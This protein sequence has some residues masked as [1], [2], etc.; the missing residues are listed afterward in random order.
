M[1]SIHRQINRH[2]TTAS[3]NNSDKYTDSINPSYCNRIGDSGTTSTVTAEVSTLFNSQNT[4]FTGVSF[5]FSGS[6]GKRVL[7]PRYVTKWVN[8][9][10]VRVSSK[11]FT[12]DKL[13]KEKE[14]HRENPQY[15]S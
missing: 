13:L 12:N 9:A 7:K 6:I 5:P 2:F 3:D 4:T 10:C 1:I 8:G 15:S 14:E 11:I